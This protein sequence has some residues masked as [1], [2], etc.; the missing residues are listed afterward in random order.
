MRNNEEGVERWVGG[1]MEG[2]KG[3]WLEGWMVKWVGGIFTLI[4]T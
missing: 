3:K 1:W 4:F 2:W